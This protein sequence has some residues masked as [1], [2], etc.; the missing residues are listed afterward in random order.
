MQREPFCS[1]RRSRGRSSN[2]G[3]SNSSGCDA[4]GCVALRCDAMRCDADAVLRTERH[5][6]RQEERRRRKQRDAAP[7]QKGTEKPKRKGRSDTNSEWKHCGTLTLWHCDSPHPKMADVAPLSLYIE[8]LD[9]SP[10]SG[11][12]KFIQRRSVFFL[13]LRGSKTSLK[14]PRTPPD[15]DK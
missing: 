13:R 2:G 5:S 12:W 8:A 6:S 9:C 15:S 14:M 3:N 7:Q 11:A 1:R 10:S 4:L